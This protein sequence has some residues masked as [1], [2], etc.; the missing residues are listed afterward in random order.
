MRCFSLYLRFP[1]KSKAKTVI[2]NM[3]FI[4]FNQFS[5]SSLAQ[6]VI[7]F[8]IMLYFVSLK[9]KSK[10][11]W[12]RTFFF[13]FLTGFFLFSFLASCVYAPIGIYFIAL[14]YGFLILAVSFFIQ[15]AYYLP[16]NDFPEESRIVFG[17]SSFISVAVIAFLIWKAT[18]YQSFLPYEHLIVNGVILLLFVWTIIVSGRQT[19]QLSRYTDEDFKHVKLKLYKSQ[20]RLTRE[21]FLVVIIIFLG[22]LPTVFNILYYSSFISQTSYLYLSNLI[23]LFFLFFFVLAYFEISPE[24][25]SVSKKMVGISLASMIAALSIVGS[26][27]M[28][29]Y[30]SAFENTRILRDN[31]TLQI[32][33]IEDGCYQII[34]KPMTYVDDLGTD[35]K[36]KDANHAKVQLGFKFPFYGKKYAELYVGSN[37]IV[38]FDQGIDTYNYFEFMRVVPKIAVLFKDL[39]P[40]TGGGVFFRQKQDTAIVTWY[41]VP[42]FGRRNENTAQLIMT[43][44]GN[45]S[46]TFN[47][48]SV[49]LPGYVGF[50]PGKEI[51]ELE[52]IKYSEWLP[53]VS[54]KHNG[55]VEDFYK[56]SREYVHRGAKIFIVGIL[57]ATIFILIIFPLFFRRTITSP[58]KILLDG[59]KRV[60]E[61]D[62][63]VV[64]PHKNEDELGY[65]AEAFNEMIVS[66]R[67]GKQ[68]EILRVELEKEEKI[69]ELELE[70]RAKELAFA[71]N[72]Q[73]S[74]LPKKDLILPAVEVVGKMRSASEVGGDYYDIIKIYDNRYCI[75]VGDATGHGVAAGLVVAMIKMALVNSIR[76]F[77]QSLSIKQLF[78]NLN[79]SLKECLPDRGMGMAL[80]IM[81]LNVDTM[82]ADI[83]AVGMPFP[84]LYSSHTKTLTPIEMTGPPL[85]FMSDI[86]VTKDV[87]LLQPGD[88][89]IFHSDGF[90]ERLDKNDELWENE[91]F[92]KALI[93][94]CKNLPDAKS[95]VDKMIEECDKFAD[96]RENNDDMTMVVLRVK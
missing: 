86:I 65:M 66:I 12:Y 96:G 93:S 7:S 11:A 63:E 2:F 29:T 81:I 55:L 5:I 89:L 41:K 87:I 92:E 53:Y 69:L 34:R 18:V 3:S 10:R 91:R 49:I 50:H 67:K 13:I 26:L 8:I 82:T 58:L 48:L 61:G 84:Y 37:G 85:G 24:P 9:N 47:G 80:S 76:S 79:L 74:M 52:S 42:D 14:Q 51:N 32:D 33:L 40:E 36:L 94:A 16:K 59:V 27:T 77:D 4:Y 60:N 28:S 23:Y 21:N 25:S 56:D 54:D 88:R 44:S 45:F 78:E 30:G 19:H 43:K 35:L 73:L 72:V 64:V 22:S 17:I 62:L 70:R 83:S 68:E 20:K 46:F 95:I 75:A 39:N 31:E 71:R 1:Y 57:I 15:F 90:T 6:L 38:S